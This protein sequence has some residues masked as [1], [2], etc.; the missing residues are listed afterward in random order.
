ME[1]LVGVGVVLMIMAVIAMFSNADKL[2]RFKQLGD[3]AGMPFDD[4]VAQVG[5]P[6][7]VSAMADGTLYQ[8]MNLAEGAS[9]HFAILFDQDNRA[10]GFTH[11]HI[12]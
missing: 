10:V 11:Q 8:W 9:Y 4:V 2:N 7:S 12:G 3:I 5:P 6:N 1:Y